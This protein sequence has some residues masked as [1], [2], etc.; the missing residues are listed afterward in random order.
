MLLT[1]L[2]TTAAI[3]LGG[4]QSPLSCPITLQPAV[5][6][7]SVTDYNGVRFTYCCPGCDKQF[8]KDPQASIDKSAKAGKTVGVFL[9]D[10]ISRTP[11]QADKAKG[12]FSDFK[13]IRF[14]FNAPEEKSTFDK[15]PLR[16]GALPKKEALYCPVSKEKVESYAKASGYDDYNGVRYYY[17]C[18]GCEKPFTAEPAKYAPNAQEF[19]KNPQAFTTVPKA[20]GL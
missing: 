2:I 6:G 15:E 13:G 11:I 1:T 12:G 16:Y 18:A 10:P 19:V 9:F 5:K 17:C 20:G 8:E 7:M 4:Q 3:S 14:Y